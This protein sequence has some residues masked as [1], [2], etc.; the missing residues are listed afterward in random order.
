MESIP[1]TR[2]A[3]DR[4]RLLPMLQLLELNGS[5]EPSHAAFLTLAPITVIGYQ[6][7]GDITSP[8][9]FGFR[10]YLRTLDTRL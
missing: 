9:L 7:L 10:K 4:R 3:R 5:R 6:I 2:L 1:S 8:T